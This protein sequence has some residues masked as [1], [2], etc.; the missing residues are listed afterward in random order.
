MPITMRLVSSLYSGNFAIFALAAS[1]YL[2]AGTLNTV[3]SIHLL[4]FD[5]EA[6]TLQHV[7]TFPANSP[8]NWITLDVGSLL[9][10]LWP[11]FPRSLNPSTSTAEKPYTEPPSRRIAQ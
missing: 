4:E 8:H 2:F 5:D 6:K 9:V 7:K 11:S 3:S 10:A 1:H